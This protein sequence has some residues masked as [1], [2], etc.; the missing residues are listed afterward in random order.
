MTISYNW[1]VSQLDCYPEHEGH[2][3]VV[4]VCH[5]R[6]DGTDDEYAAGVYGSVGLTL[7]PE[8][9]FTPFEKLT[10]AQVIG[11]VKDAL[12][13]DQ[14]TSYEE[15]VANQIEALINPPVVNPPL[16]WAAA[17]VEEA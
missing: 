7:D 4:F 2:T 10:E 8:A 3:D 6:M 11:W 1:T 13:E 14:V 12:G 15:N 17:P 16:P 9:K 5:W